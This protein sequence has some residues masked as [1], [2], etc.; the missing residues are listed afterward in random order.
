MIKLHHKVYA[1]G[2]MIKCFGIVGIRIGWLLADKK[3]YFKCRDYKDYLTH[4]IPEI[5]SLKNK[6]KIILDK[7]K[8]ILKNLSFLNNFMEKNKNVFEYVPPQGVWCV[9]QN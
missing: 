4:T 8:D 5:L 7:K 2:S 3:Y 1:T 9:F 6:N